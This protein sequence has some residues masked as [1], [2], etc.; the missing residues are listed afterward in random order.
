[1]KLLK[2]PIVRVVLI[3]LAVNFAMKFIRPKVATVPVLNQL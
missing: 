2:N 3:V 1:M